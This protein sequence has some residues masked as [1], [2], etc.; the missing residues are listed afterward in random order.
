MR[1]TS[2]IPQPARF[3]LW[4]FVAWMVMPLNSGRCAEASPVRKAELQTRRTWN[5]G[6]VHFSNEFSGA[7]LNSCEQISTNE[8]KVIISPENEPINRSPWYAFKVWSETR[9][10]IS[11]RFVYT[12]GS[13]RTRPWLSRD[14]EKWERL[15]ERDHTVN[16]DL[17]EG[18]ARLT[19]GPKPLWV[20]AQEMIGLKQLEV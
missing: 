20:A 19:I 16:R 18:T 6:D 5:F 3:L 8:F 17:G 4:L 7:R 10:K 2:K 9:R 11:V 1:R 12:Y 14:G 15:A 13:H